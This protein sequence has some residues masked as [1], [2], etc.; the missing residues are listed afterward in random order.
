VNVGRK[1]IT[2]WPLALLLLAPAAESAS[3]TE[4]AGDVLFVLLP[5]AGFAT[6]LIKQDREGQIQFAKAFAANAVATLGLKSAI[7]KQRPNGDCCDAFPSGHSSFAFMG[8]TFI[9]RRYGW[10]Y[11]APAYAAASFV[12][13]SRVDADKHYV[14]DVVAGAAIG[15]LSSYF[16]TTR[17]PNVSITPIAQRDFAGVTFSMQW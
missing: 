12:A 7:D 14:E 1:W 6:A 5:V 8:A 13:Y 11:G 4:D 2:L 17:Y 10:K 9:E 16:F 15:Y 3:S